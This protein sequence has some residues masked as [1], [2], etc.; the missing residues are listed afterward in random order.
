MFLKSYDL[1]FCIL[2]ALLIVVVIV[3]VFSYQELVRL[4]K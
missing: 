2:H 3:V 1:W 4:L